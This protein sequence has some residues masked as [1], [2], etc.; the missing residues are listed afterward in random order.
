[1]TTGCRFAHGLGALAEYLMWCEPTL[2]IE[3]CVQSWGPHQ[4]RANGWGINGANARQ[5]EGF[6]QSYTSW[7]HVI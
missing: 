4:G 7:R 2:G 5:H 1:M 6:T 3:A